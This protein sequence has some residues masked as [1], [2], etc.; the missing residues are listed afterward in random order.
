MAYLVDNL[1]T[2]LLNAQSNWWGTI[3]EI[4][5]AAQVSPTIDYSGYT[6]E[7]LTDTPIAP[8]KITDIT[9][10]ADSASLVWVPANEADVVGYK[11]YWG[12][13]PAP[14]WDHV[15]DA[16]ANTA[17][18]LSGLMP[19]KAYYFALTAYDDGLSDDLIGTPVNENQLSGNESWYSRPVYLPQQELQNNSGGGAIS[20][21][22]WLLLFVY[23]IGANLGRNTPPG[24]SFR[25]RSLRILKKVLRNSRQTA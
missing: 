13:N 19:D 8:P 23:Q 25:R 21:L 2:P 17:I 10:T 6:L 9:Y 11:V 18:I 24:A 12:E 7:A 1:N 4:E 20:N 22:S 16:G 15:M 5:L 14:Q 3:D